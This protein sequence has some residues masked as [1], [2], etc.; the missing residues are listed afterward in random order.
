MRLDNLRKA[1]KIAENVSVDYDGMTPEEI[2]EI[3]DALDIIFKLAKTAIERAE[4]E[5][6]ETSKLNKIQEITARAL[7]SLD[8]INL[9]KACCINEIAEILGVKLE[10]PAEKSDDNKDQITFDDII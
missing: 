6:E 10:D 7:R 2:K 3:D 1:Y 4:S 8:P 9:Y 5:A